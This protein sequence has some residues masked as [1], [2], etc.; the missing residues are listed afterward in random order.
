MCQGVAG[1]LSA[2]V[3][4][5][6]PGCWQLFSPA[7][8][9]LT[10]EPALRSQIPASPWQPLATAAMALSQKPQIFFVASSQCQGTGVASKWMSGCHSC[11]QDGSF[12]HTQNSQNPQ[13]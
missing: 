1:S 5:F 13:P 12:F 9:S 8:P 2:A 11:R 10:S 7:E 3:Q 6:L 4:V